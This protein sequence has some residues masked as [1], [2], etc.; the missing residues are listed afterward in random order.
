MRHTFTH[1]LDYR[2]ERDF[3][4]K[5]NATFAFIQAQ[6]RPLTRVL[7]YLVLPVALLSGI[8]MGIGQAG[9]FS[10]LGQG[11][12][13]LASGAFGSVSSGLA[14]M[15]GVGGALLTYLLL[16]ATLYEYVRLRM[17]LPADEEVTPALVWSQ[18][19]SS[20]WWILLSGIILT[21]LTGLGF[22]FLFFPGVYLAVAL[23]LFFAVM[24]ME[25]NGFSK[26]FSRCFEL[27][28][29]HWW[30]TFGLLFIMWIIQSFA[31]FIFQIPTYLLMG[32]KMAH[33]PIPG[34]EML[35]IATQV[36]ATIGQVLLYTPTMLAI[37]FQYFNLVERKDGVGMRHLVDSIG[38]QP[39]TTVSS[40]AYRPDEEGEY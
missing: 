6:G 20:V 19:R 12:R 3:G 9:V 14:F 2:Q 4:Q 29:G 31:G 15:T 26:N 35:A 8:G 28:S 13:G 25:R 5:I 1:E 27:V 32:L 40:A 11:R 17:T 24:I 7:L 16:T 33:I 34:E 23:S 18:V 37:L 30:S 39:A 36:F 22:V 38:Q 10:L 21:V